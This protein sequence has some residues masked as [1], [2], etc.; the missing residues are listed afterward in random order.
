MA[1][2]TIANKIHGSNIFFLRHCNLSARMVALQAITT[3]SKSSEAFRSTLNNTDVRNDLEHSEGTPSDWSL[4]RSM[5]L[6]SMDNQPMEFCSIIAS[7]TEHN[8]TSPD[9]VVRFLS[10]VLLDHH[11]YQHGCPYMNTWMINSIEKVME[12]LSGICV[13]CNYTIRMNESSG[14]LLDK[15]VNFARCALTSA[16]LATC[17]QF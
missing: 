17:F 13:K 4:I 15:L 11:W 14:V 2:S 5:C 16:S 12:T 3:L 10:S 6:A 8:E 7:S 1:L 9:G